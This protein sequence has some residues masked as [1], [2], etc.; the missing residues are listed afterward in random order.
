MGVARSVAGGPGVFWGAG[1]SSPRSGGPGGGPG[2]GTISAAYAVAINN[3]TGTVD[4]GGVI[5]GIKLGVGMDGAGPHKVTLS[6]FGA[7]I[8]GDKAISIAG[9]S[10]Y[11]YTKGTID[12][13][14]Y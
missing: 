7:S 11:I 12:G 6:S 10:G 5:N 3:G 8:S 13:L 1:A 14:N 9:G 4:T 2:G